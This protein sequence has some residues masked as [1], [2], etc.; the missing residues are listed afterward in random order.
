MLLTTVTIMMREQ[1]QKLATTPEKSWK[2][3]K[4]GVVL[5][6]FSVGLIIAGAQLN[7][8]LQIPGLL[9]LGAALLFSGW[10]YLGILSSR[11]LDLQNNW[12]KHTKKKP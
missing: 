2:R 6:A 3:F 4:L 7:H 8:L 9:M 11:L 1:L 12:L 10:G 5:F